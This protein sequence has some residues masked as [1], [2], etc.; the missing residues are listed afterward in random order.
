MN[1]A[2][3]AEIKA[4][5]PIKELVEQRVALKPAGAGVWKGL[6]PFHREKTPSFFVYE[7]SNRFFCFSC[8]AKGDHFDWMDRIDGLPF[9]DALKE[10][11]SRA[12]VT[13]TE[14]EKPQESEAVKRQRSELERQHE[15]FVEALHTR[16]GRDCLEYLRSRGLTDETIA[17]FGLGYAPNVL[18]LGA[19][20]G[21]MMV[22]LRDEIG[23]LVGFAGRS[24]HRD[25][26]PKYVNSRQSDIFDK[27]SLI[28]NL[29]TAKRYIRVRGEA[30]VFEGYTD[31]MM[32]SQSGYRYC[33]AT[34]GTA[35]TAKQAAALVRLKT[36]LV[37]CLDG[38]KAGQMASLRGIKTFSEAGTILPS[39]YIAT[40]PDGKDPGDLL[41]RGERE[42][43]DRCIKAAQPVI[44]FLIATLAGNLPDDAEGKEVSEVVAQVGALVRKFPD[45]IEREHYVVQL[46]KAVGLDVKIVRAVVTGEATR[47]PDNKQ[48][49]ERV[50]HSPIPA[51]KQADRPLILIGLL[52][53]DPGRILPMESVVTRAHFTSRPLL[54]A[55]W[56]S[57][58]ATMKLYPDIKD[59]SDLL[60]SLT[61]PELRRHVQE[62][63]AEVD[64]WPLLGAR[65]MWEKEVRDLAA[66]LERQEA[67]TM[68]DAAIKA[69]A[70]VYSTDRERAG[71]LQQHIIGLSEVISGPR[72]D[73]FTKKG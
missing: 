39:L 21:R 54:A 65:N 7:D 50:I 49:E 13:L 25:V 26:K 57:L 28:Y 63:I 37:L 71:V 44:T 58:V 70:A 47:R 2:E 16:Q 29:G 61:A 51:R 73:Y 17:D 42:V 6:C 9:P 10:L 55:A 8:D 64:S 23:Q 67:M 53:S 52:A 62:A 15:S 14:P 66:L 30:L 1:E 12:G 35:I 41:E 22:P 4:R 3:V 33:V 40:M 72:S 19:F 27:G 18:R 24:L 43:F 68:R 48:E 5:I 11:A 36:R 45:P 34:M 20:A 38:D 31:V 56:A 46:A 59:S 32:A 60:S 69:L